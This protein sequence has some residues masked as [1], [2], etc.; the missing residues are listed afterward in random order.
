MTLDEN[1]SSAGQL[2]LFVLV[3]RFDGR[4]RK[5]GRPG[6][7]FD[8]NYGRPLHRDYVRLAKPFPLTLGDD[9]VPLFLEEFD[10][11]P[12]AVLP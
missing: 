8:K 6:F 11:Q 4:S 1:L 2:S 9:N 5:R 3:D 7:D 10:R 12:F